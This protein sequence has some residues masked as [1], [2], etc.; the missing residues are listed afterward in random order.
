LVYP[1]DT[2]YPLDA[3]GE[4]LVLDHFGGVGD[5]TEIVMRSV[6][7]TDAIALLYMGWDRPKTWF[8]DAVGQSLDFYPG[9]VW[10]RKITSLDAVSY[11]P[12]HIVEWVSPDIAD[13]TGS[14]EGASPRAIDASDLAAWVQYSTGAVRWGFEDEN[15][16]NSPTWEVDFNPLGGS[17]GAND[18]SETATMATV[19]GTSC[20]AGKTT[21][22]GNAEAR[23][24]MEWFGYGLTGRTIVI[25]NDGTAV[26]EWELVDAEQRDRAI[27]NPEGWRDNINAATVRNISWSATKHLY[28]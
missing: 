2:Q 16:A 26:P 22:E 15:P 12:V 28:R 5:R 7:D 20:S 25:D 24:A 17:Q 23:A 19:L 10:N 3:D 18:A 14:S 27:E 11:Y 13:I 6:F 9:E 21:Q 8:D 4:F 1:Y